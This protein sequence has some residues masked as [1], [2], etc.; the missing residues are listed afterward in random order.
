MTGEKDR[1]DRDHADGL[2]GALV[3]VAGGKTAA[4]SDFEFHLELVLPVER[5]D[6]LLRVDEF[7]ILIGLDVPGGHHAF[8][9]DDEGESAAR[10]PGR[11]A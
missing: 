6:E 8:F 10:D 4:D 7:E 3:F 11:R 2:I 5:A 1:I 9:V